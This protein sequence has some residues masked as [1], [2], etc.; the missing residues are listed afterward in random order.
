MT[1][2]AGHAGHGIAIWI[3]PYCHTNGMGHGGSTYHGTTRVP[4]YVRTYSS[5]YH[6]Y[7]GTYTCTIG[8][9][10]LKI[11]HTRV[12]TD[13]PRWYTC[14]IMVRTRVPFSWHGNVQ[15]SM[16]PWYSSTT[17]YHGT[18]HVYHGTNWYQWYVR[19]R[20][21][22]QL[23]RVLEYLMVHVYLWYQYVPTSQLVHV[24][25]LSSF[26]ACAM[27]CHNFL[28][29]RTYTCTVHVYVQH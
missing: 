21:L 9:P 7:H 19:T 29:V 18:T 10:Y 16:V 26:L 2:A 14:T 13:V 6:W 1:A 23:V 8:M 28:I 25:V 24:Y 12:R 27:L 4:W 11:C 15:S 22:Y 3:L 5:R 17:W 20:V